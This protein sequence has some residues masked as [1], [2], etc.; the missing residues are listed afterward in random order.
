MWGKEGKNC[1]SKPQWY[2]IL[3]FKL[4][5]IFHFL[6]SM[7]TDIFFHSNG[8][9]SSSNLSCKIFLEVKHSYWYSF[10][11]RWVTATEPKHTCTIK[12]AHLVARI[13]FIACIKILHAYA[14]MIIYLCICKA[15]LPFFGNSPQF[16]N[17]FS[18]LQNNK[19][20]KRTTLKTTK[21]VLFPL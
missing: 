11:N 20:Q 10:K 16:R 19:K 6:H 18:I 13:K 5:D 2:Y 21:P 1:M 14:N 12:Y 3:T 7:L 9:R 4:T 8:F 17:N 15:V